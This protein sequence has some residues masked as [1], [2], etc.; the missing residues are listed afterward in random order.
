MLLSQLE[1]DICGLNRMVVLSS[2][3]LF[4]VNCRPPRQQRISVCVR[5]RPLTH[6][7]RRRGEEDV[8]T[9]SSEACVTVNE[10]K[11]AVDLSQYVLQ[12][13]HLRTLTSREKPETGWKRQCCECRPFASAA[14]VLFRSGFW[15]GKHQ[16]RSVSE[17]RISS[18]AAHAPQVGS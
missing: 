15:G 17:N 13:D 3:W 5:K 10:R 4:C 16:R 14:Q 11:E 2:M 12:V 1:G 9:T 8:V 6:T 7:E 18:G